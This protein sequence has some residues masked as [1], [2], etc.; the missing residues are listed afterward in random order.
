[1]NL[2]PIADSFW[3]LA[4][5][6]PSIGRMVSGS[7]LALERAGTRPRGPGTKKIRPKAAE[8]SPCRARGA[9][10]GTRGRRAPRDRALPR[11]FPKVQPQADL[12]ITA[13]CV[14]DTGWGSAW[15][16][17]ERGEPCRRLALTEQGGCPFA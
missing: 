12:G 13:D 9:P 15:P 8:T 10:D 3:A 7:A 5:V 4:L 17:A 2:I 14:W 6:A 1:M 11:H 16:A